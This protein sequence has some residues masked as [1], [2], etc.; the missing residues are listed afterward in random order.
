MN[1]CI[2][3]DRDGV[4]NKEMGEYVFKHEDF[5]VLDGV[6]EAI[7]QL[8]AAGYLL[9]V[10][11]NQSGIAKGLYTKS[12]V[13]ACHE[14]LQKECNYLIDDLYFSPHHEDYDTASLLKKPNSLMIE[15][16]MAKHNIDPSQS[17][18][19]GD[20]MRDIIAGSKAGLK[21]I[22]VSQSSSNATAMANTPSLLEA[23]RLIN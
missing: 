6:K 13:L 23:V 16:A 8:K 19:I 14:I 21:T 18:M 10:I 1:K 3:L 9:I 11:T 20:Q 4:L 15:K 7:H 5:L 17:Y 12:E 22:F 2:F